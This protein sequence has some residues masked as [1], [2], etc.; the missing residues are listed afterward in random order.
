MDVGRSYQN[1]PTLEA[2]LPTLVTTE[3]A[4]CLFDLMP[5][6]EYCMYDQPSGE[7]DYASAALQFLTVTRLVMLRKIHFY[8]ASYDLRGICHDRV[9]LNDYLDALQ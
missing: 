3:Q 7:L 2:L 5:G 8:H 9:N 1:P 4:N 6:L